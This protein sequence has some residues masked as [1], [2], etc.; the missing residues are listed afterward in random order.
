[1]TVS[2][3]LR[4]FPNHTPETRAKVLKIAEELNYK[5]NPLI[6]A[7]MSSRRQRKPTNFQ[8]TIALIQCNQLGIY[9]TQNRAKLR[10]GI[11]IGAK[12]QGFDVE[13]FQINEGGVSPERLMKV[14]AARG[15]GCVIF[16]PFPRAD[17]ELEVDMSGFASLSLTGSLKS[18]NLNR[19]EIDHYSAFFLAEQNAKRK[20]YQRIGFVSDP[21]PLAS[22]ENRRR[23]AYLLAE[24]GV[25]SKNK[26][27]ELSLS[28]DPALSVSQL[29]KW[30]GKYAPDVLISS[31]SKAPDYLLEL[32]Y[33]IP[34]DFGYI[35][36]GLSENEG[37]TTGINPNWQ[38]VGITAANQVIEALVTNNLGL[39]L[40][41]RRTSIQPFWV[42]GETLPQRFAPSL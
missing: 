19:V 30:L 35:Q 42:P 31:V 40:F 21:L 24:D 39:P 10:E 1:M 28:S 22:H 26:I 20:G 11:E 14:I 8:T 32:G 25:P 36:L 33:E 37:T 4:N 16:E 9:T 6:T 3:I 23:A 38:E 29:K 41:P 27:P 2:R 34:R 17:V 13:A 18:P 15:M 7:L 5:K 12:F